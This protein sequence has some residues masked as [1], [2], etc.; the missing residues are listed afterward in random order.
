MKRLLLG[1]V[2]LPFLVGVSLAAQPVPLSDTQMD[3][4]TAGFDFVEIERQNT[5]VVGVWVNLRAPPCAT[6]Y[7]TV[8]NTYFNNP[9]APPAMVT[10]SQFG[11]TPL[12]GT[13]LP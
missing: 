9:A 6:C 10:Q 5:G 4:V 3:A 11:P 2:A 7:L 1:L 13:G 12:L 8:T